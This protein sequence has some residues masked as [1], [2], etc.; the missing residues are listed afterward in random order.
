M[1][2]HILSL[3][4][5]TLSIASSCRVPLP[6]LPFKIRYVSKFKTI[7]DTVWI[8][9]GLYNFSLRWKNKMW[10]RQTV[11]QFT[12]HSVGGVCQLKTI[13]T[14]PDA[15]LMSGYGWVSD[16]HHHSGCHHCPMLSGSFLPPLACL[17]DEG[18]EGAALALVSGFQL[19]LWGVG[20]AEGAIEGGA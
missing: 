5:L 14:T 2:L 15:P 9:R 10:Q 18:P 16:N 8:G 3:F 7:C 13:P 1:T 6:S 17:C 12:D 4:T 19:S 11:L 20:G